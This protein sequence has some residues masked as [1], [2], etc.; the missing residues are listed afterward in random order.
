MNQLDLLT[1]EREDLI[2]AS[3][4]LEESIK[5][6]NIM[7]DSGFYQKIETQIN[8][9]QKQ[10]IFLDEEIEK[11]KASFNAI[12]V[13]QKD[14]GVILVAKN[15]DDKDVFLRIAFIAERAKSKNKA[16]AFFFDWVYKIEDACFITYKDYS[17]TAKQFSEIYTFHKK[18]KSIELEI[19][20]GS[21][22][23]R[24]VEREVKH[25]YLF[26]ENKD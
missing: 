18:N 23:L 19:K 14:I 4:C 12:V 22:K 1:E 15:K 3:G 13:T 17:I 2:K 9:M 21:P 7:R 6:L 16:D 8:T 25:N 11:T 5:Y 24:N 20:K 26:K 10:I